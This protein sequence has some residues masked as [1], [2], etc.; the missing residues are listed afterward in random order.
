MDSQFLTGIEALR[1]AKDIIGSQAA[2]AAVVGVKQPS[3]N[4][5]LTKADCVTAEW[6]IPID[7][8][9]SKLGR[10]VSCHQLRPD[11]W[12]ADFVPPPVQE[13]A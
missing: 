9:T 2:L 13:A 8:M 10:R 5:A 4:Y 12:P 7:R 11:L 1:L 6:C 3:V